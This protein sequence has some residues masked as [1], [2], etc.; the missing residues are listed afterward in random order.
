MLV[1]LRFAHYTPGAEREL[2]LE[3]L[4]FRQGRIMHLKVYP[5]SY[6]R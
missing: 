3:G 6:N 5:A 4:N 1:S 2:F